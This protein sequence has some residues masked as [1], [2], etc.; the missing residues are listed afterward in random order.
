MKISAPLSK[1]LAALLV[2][3][4]LL[5]MSSLVRKLA[6]AFQAKAIIA[7]QIQTFSSD[8][9]KGKYYLLFFY[10]LDFTFVC[11]TEL[12]AFSDR[13]GEFRD[14]NC[15]LLASSV[16]S[17][18]A[19]LAWIQTPRNKGGLGEMKFPL[20][21][22]VSKRIAAGFDALLAEEGVALRASFIVDPQGMVRHASYN[23][24][25]IGRSVDEMLRLVKAIQFFD[26][27]GE[28]CPA[29]WQPGSKTIKAHPD[30]SKEFFESVHR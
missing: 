18:Y 17:E 28:V 5:V 19:H 2:Q 21:A 3:G 4:S 29:N 16:D 13:A 23:D 8:Q 26:K 9:L 10:P 11:P 12:T 20:L 30:D 22:D 14:I 6:P 15:E 7:N 25:P 27:H 24:L 1:T